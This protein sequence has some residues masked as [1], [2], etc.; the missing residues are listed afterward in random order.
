MSELT[1]G[2]QIARHHA[3]AELGYP[4]DPDRWDTLVRQI[5]AEGSLHAELSTTI[6]DY[7]RSAL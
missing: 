6:F 1:I 7:L 3:E 2:Q 5:E 4:I